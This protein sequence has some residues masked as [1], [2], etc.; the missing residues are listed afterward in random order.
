MAHRLTPFVLLAFACAPGADEDAALQGTPVELDWR[1]G[2]SW[3][4][5]ASYRQ[6]ANKGVGSSVDLE[7]LEGD[8]LAE[9]WSDEVIWTYQVVETAYIPSEGDELYPY[10]KT[11]TGVASLAV[12][13]AQATESLNDDPA[14]LEADPVVYMV[15][16][17]DRDRLAG[18]ITY[19]NVDGERV[20]RAVSSTKLNRSWGVLSQS[21]LS[22]APTYLA[23]SSARWGDDERRLENG[24]LVTSVEMGDEITDI[25]FDD[26][27]S[28]GLV[29]TR[30]EAGQPWPT[31]TV[32]DSLNARVL[33][34]GEVEAIRR[35]LPPMYPDSED[36][37]Y[38]A[39]LQSSTDIDATLTLTEEMIS[40]EGWEAS[41][42]DGFLPWAGAWWPLKK[43]ELVFGYDGRDTLSD[44]IKDDI[45]P[46]KED[47]DALQAELREIDDRSSSE[48]TEKVDS[49]KEKQSELV[50]KLVEFYGGV[51][52]DLD[53]G[54]LTV[55]D[56]KLTHEDGW[57]YDIDELSPMDKMALVKYL[58]GEDYPNPFYMPAWELLNSYNPGGD[59]WWGHCNGWAAAAILTN[60]PRESVTFDADGHEV[61]FTTADQKGLLTE[62]HYSTYSH[63]YGQRYNG[64][65]DDITDITPAAF[66]NI[67]S[68]YIKD[69]GVPLVFDTTASEAVWNFPAYAVDLDMEET[70]PEGALDL[71]NINTATF[72]ALDELPQVGE[73]KAAAII[74]HREKY[75]A[76]QAKE[77]IMDVDGVGEGTY[78]DIVD[79][80]TV[81]PIERTFAVI[82]TVTHTTD[83]V[84]ETHIDGSTPE[85][86]DETWGYT[87]VTDETGTVLRGTWDQEDKHPDFAWVPYYNPDSAG[88]GSSENPYLGYDD[89]KDVLGDE[90]ERK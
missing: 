14:I 69:Q 2:D 51:L 22:L 16:R 65:D 70:T 55:A 74:E 42:K 7:T 56:G 24:K 10:A 46:L 3:H 38:K 28:G 4:V 60:E 61:T 23:P 85:S 17:E 89:I 36:F 87:L 72:E 82:A 73:S 44:R 57:S 64:D 40:D 35:D 20:E 25:F 58:E 37:D 21:Q 88:N 32:T 79:L 29:A 59:S 50:D 63:F 66:Q 76:F 48:Y 86:F 49:Y 39:A 43:G 34:T 67:V 84:D 81:D 30:Y 77:D 62:S 83:G 53:G 71:V 52:T 13:R 12:V 75:G 19:L 47:M 45:D 6:A 1:T 41:A 11:R 9:S 8:A 27:M 90:I 80:I 68:F 5:A 54:K 31:W 18:V 26:E 78:D 15:F 33:G